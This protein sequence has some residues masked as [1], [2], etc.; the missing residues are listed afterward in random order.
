MPLAGR[1]LF[2]I[3]V[4][5]GI[6]PP[7]G[8]LPR[9]LENPSREWHQLSHR[10]LA[11][12]SS[13][14]LWLPITAVV[15]LSAGVIALRVLR[16][17]ELSRGGRLIRVLTPPT[18]D[19]A[20]A[21]T[22]WNNLIPLLRPAWKRSLFGQPH[23]TFEISADSGGLRFAIWVPDAV[24]PA[25]V[26]QAAEAAWPGARTSTEPATPPLP[27][28]VAATGGR[29][30]LARPDALP[31]KTDHPADPLRPLLGALSGI[32]EG[33]AACI[34]LLAR[35]VTGRRLARLRT[36][37]K[38]RRAAGQSAPGK[39][40]P[41]PDPFQASELAGMVIKAASPAFAVELRYA[42][43]TL[44]PTTSRSVAEGE[45]AV[46][47]G[48]AHA[49][50]SAY[51]AYTGLNGLVRRP[52]RMPVTQLAGR[53]LGR[54]Q[55]MSVAEVA[56]LAHLPL[57]VTVPGLTRAGARSVIA[58][59]AI[60]TENADPGAEFDG[61]F[62]DTADDFPPMA[63]SISF[64]AGRVS[65]AAGKPGS[66]SRSHE[67]GSSSFPAGQP[68]S[69]DGDQAGP[70]RPPIAAGKLLGLTARGRRVMLP[71]ADGRHHFHIL[72][73]T[74]SGKSTLLTNLILDDI[75]AGRGVAVIDPKGDLITDL[76]D[77]IPE[78][79]AERI[80]LL[81]PDRAVTG[82]PFT[83]ALNPLAGPDPQLA[84]DHLT[85]IFRR[86]FAAF[87]GPRTDDLMRTACLTLL[88][89]AAQHQQT[90]NF[91][92]L[93]QLL[94]DPIFRARVTADLDDPAGLGGFWST[95]ESLGDGGRSQTIGPL[96]N[97]LRAFLLRDFVRAAVSASPSGDALSP[98]ARVL[99]GGILLARLP[100]GLLG[101]DTSRLLGS[102]LVAQIWQAATYQ[103]QYGQ[104]H[105]RDASLYVD[106]C[107]NFLTLPHSFDDVLAEARGYHLSLILAH[108]H[109]GQLPTEL[110]AALSSNAR[111]KIYFPVSPEDAHQLERHTLPELGAYDLAHSS[112]FTAAARLVVDGN[113]TPAFTLHTRPAPRPAPGRAQL[114]RRAAADHMPATRSTRVTRRDANRPIDSPVD[115]GIGRP[116]HSPIALSTDH[117]K[118]PIDAAHRPGDPSQA[119]AD[120]TG[121]RL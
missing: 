118:R 119:G 27:E 83:V 40:A 18:V 98:A 19:P 110:R 38:R 82:G 64:P 51:A 112:G 88:A 101:D 21:L 17:R 75:A 60:P 96:L 22:F 109:L 56:A 72:G 12:L 63:D 104:L 47:R 114:L 58:A 117:P 77:R 115:T 86:I 4:P 66:T 69:T 84:V 16:Q 90:A 31:L 78:Q 116:I 13:P 3:V 76:L 57:D 103:S 79:S 53:R 28:Q 30:R 41:A 1:P 73:A 59:A 11:G 20:G 33:Q 93:P 91:A 62:N 10:L 65:S 24:P 113:N 108:Q 50:A 8:L 67:G 25:M 106:E 9:L 61:Y 26:E 45:A 23:L 5:S 39:P 37:T 7:H 107:H 97:K 89:Y 74:G 55:L 32:D 46:R 35:P 71:V 29:L 70:V 95:Y 52:L 14:T 42:V 34:Q 99:D 120:I 102:F 48:Q 6:T 43:A 85:G 81:D 36:A 121:E 94:T 105:R 49:I 111:N 68:T 54:G 2:P 44:T 100:K 80:M 87:W 92:E 15:L